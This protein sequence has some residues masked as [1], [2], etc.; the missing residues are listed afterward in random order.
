[1]KDAA[2]VRSGSSVVGLR[3]DVDT[4]YGLRWGLSKIISVEKKYGVRSTF[5]VRVDVVRSDKDK[6]VLK[7]IADEGWEIGLH[8]I[9]TI[10][11]SRLISPEKEL[12]LLKRLLDVSVYGV[13][14]CGSTIGFKGDVTW[15]IMDSLG[16]KYMEG[17]G[18]PDFRVDT[19]VFPTH[20]PLDIHYVRNFGEKEGYQK[21][22]ED[23]LQQLKQNGIA[24][25]L[26]HPE[27]FVRS[28]QSHGLMKVPL[29]VLRRGMMNK[30]YEKFLCEFKGEVEFRKYIDIVSGF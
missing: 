23:L 21:F 22:K 2:V 8:L 13:T 3:H 20:M 12:K 16:L 5:F 25:V 4:V 26:V 1:V 11:D 10:N 17:Y 24:T 28:V 19:F 7:R 9:N 6:N 30:V 14:P 27:G 18:M 29:T 15:R